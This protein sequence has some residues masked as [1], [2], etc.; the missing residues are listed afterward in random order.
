MKHLFKM[1]DGVKSS[2]I[3][4]REYTNRFGEIANHTIL[5]GSNRESC[6]MRDLEKLKAELPK[7]DGVKREACEEL[8]Q[9]LLKPSKTRSDAQKDAYT[10]IVNGVKVHNESGRIY[11][12]GRHMAKEI[13]AKGVYPNVNSRQKTIE[14]RKLEKDLKLE[15]C[16]YREYGVD[17][18]SQI[19]I[20]GTVL[21]ATN[22]FEFGVK[23]H[24]D[25]EVCGT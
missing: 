14:K 7:L 5:I 23:E 15:N 19:A 4:V 11:I 24:I 1:F 10:H 12:Y 17:R 2:F 18:I 21:D 8:I 22:G 20:L 16:L 6:K 9:S 13:I 25:A 3:G